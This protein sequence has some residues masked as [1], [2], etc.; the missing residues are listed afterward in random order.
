[1]PSTQVFG[2]FW[3]EHPSLEVLALGFLPG[4]A[5]GVHLAGLLFFLNPNLPFGPWS[6]IRASLVFGCVLGCASAALLAPFTW[7]R[8]PRARRIL[9]WAM[10]AVLAAAALVDGANASRY[11]LFLPPGINVRLIKAAFGLGVAALIFFYTALSHTMQRRPYGMRSRIG[12]VLLAALTI[13][14]VGE[15]REAFRPRPR[16]TPLPSS[17]ELE[18]RPDLLVVGLDGA[19]LDAVLPLAQ[20]GRLPFF[21]RLLEQ[22]SYARL[23]SF[24]PIVPAAQWTTLA[25]GKLPFKHGISGD[26]V[27]P[28]RF[29]AGE[30]PLRLRPAHIGF[31]GW[32]RLLHDSRPVDADL[33]H[34]LVLWEI[35][36]RLGV[37]TG[38]LGWPASS[39]VPE[40]LDFAFSDLYFTG[41]G[42]RDSAAPAEL[43]E[44]GLLFRVAP[45]ELDPDLASALGEQ[46]PYDLLETV[47]GDLWRESLSEFLW[48]QRATTRARFLMLPGLG[49]VSRAYFG[50]YSHAQF[51]GTQRRSHLRA[52]ESVIDY[53]GHLDGFLE[54]GWNRLGERRLLAVVSAH[55]YAPPSGLG[56]LWRT[57]TG[58]GLEGQ[59]GDAPDGLLLLAGEG[60]QAG[61]LPD[62]AALVDVTPT[63]LYAMGMPIARDLDGEVLTGAFESSFLA[64]HPLTF[65][66]SYDTLAGQAPAPPPPAPPNPFSAPS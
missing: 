16:P 14:L 41:E 20:Q 6:L 60:V 50:G 36:G 55:G 53:Y 25:S 29:L 44:R 61:P 3:R 65:V 13:Y 1:L 34:S 39:P 42:G 19:T 37:P 47:A 26:Q 18:P 4:L 57:L 28:A 12:M 10:T 51:E 63:L 43:A 8:P 38:M 23:E 24:A 66:P 21:A 27:F 5:A 35:F 2:R 52:A 11:S 9:P 7:G 46:V 17:V 49:A 15:R 59:T 58:R 30:A 54:R 31:E 62:R 45:E 40:G 56:R 32:G 33:R 48:D 64:R 22:G